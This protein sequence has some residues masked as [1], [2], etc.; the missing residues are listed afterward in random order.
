MK[1]SIPSKPLMEPGSDYYGHGGQPRGRCLP[2]KR[3]QGFLLHIDCL[4]LWATR[5]GM[6]GKFRPQGGGYFSQVRFMEECRLK[7]ES[8][9]ARATDSIALLKY[10]F[11]SKYYGNVQVELHALLL[12]FGL[13][14]QQKKL[15]LH[16][17]FCTY[18]PE[19]SR[20]NHKSVSCGLGVVSSCYVS[21]RRSSIR[22]SE[23]QG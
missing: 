7:S 8:S 2:Q 12:V 22:P 17:R 15:R 14:S 13:N 3:S 20:I 23:G 18:T 11:N 21:Q 9:P 5:P 10:R 6:N 4:V 1:Y 16:F 19:F